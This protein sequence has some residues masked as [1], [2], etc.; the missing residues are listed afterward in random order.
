MKP[1]V[2][3]FEMYEETG[4]LEHELT[5]LLFKIFGQEE[6]TLHNRPWTIGD[7]TYDSYDY[8]FELMR[9]DPNWEPTG[10]QLKHAWEL[11]FSRCWINY[12]DDTERYASIDTPLGKKYPS[13]RTT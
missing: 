7:I 11:G 6:Q 12:T 3:Y 2:K 10:E 13:H 5:D 8:S 1:A 4:V 9:V